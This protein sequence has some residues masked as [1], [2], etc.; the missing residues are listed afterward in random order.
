MAWG[1]VKDAGRQHPPYDFFSD[2]NVAGQKEIAHSTRALIRYTI[3]STAELNSPYFATF[4]LGCIKL[5]ETCVCE[6]FEMLAEQIET[7][8]LDN[9]IVNVNKLRLFAI[10]SNEGMRQCPWL[11]E[12]TGGVLVGWIDTFEKLCKPLCF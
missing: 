4:S 9:A 6:W 8:A 2:Q 7:N 5:L 11:D 1:P 3:F 12:A 10:V